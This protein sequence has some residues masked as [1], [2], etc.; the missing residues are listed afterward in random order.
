MSYCRFGEADV[1]VFECCYGWLEC[2]SCALGD[3]W[4]FDTVSAMR[5]HLLEHQRKGHY[6]P[7]SVLSDLL[8][9]E[10]D[11]LDAKLAERRSAEAAHRPLGGGGSGFPTLP[12]PL[13]REKEEEHK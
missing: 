8:D 12:S 6:V 3:N 9:D 10:E 4:R 1:Y 5:E 11:G 13:N 2:C 7:D